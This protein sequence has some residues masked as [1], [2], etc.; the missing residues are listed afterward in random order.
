MNGE[1]LVFPTR[2]AMSGESLFS[3]RDVLGPCNYSSI[4][5]TQALQGKGSVR[6]GTHGCALT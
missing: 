3:P 4:G 6:A 1:S 5:H 2:A